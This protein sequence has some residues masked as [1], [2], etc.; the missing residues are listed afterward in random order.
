LRGR[1]DALSYSVARSSRSERRIL[2][3][4]G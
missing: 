2:S 1:S 4:A 3:I